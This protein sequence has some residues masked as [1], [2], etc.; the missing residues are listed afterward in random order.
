[1]LKNK[2]LFSLLTLTIFVGINSAQPATDAATKINNILSKM[3]VINTTS[4]AGCYTEISP[5][6]HINTYNAN[7]KLINSTRVSERTKNLLN[8]QNADKS[9]QIEAESSVYG[10]GI[11]LKITQAQDKTSKLITHIRP[12]TGPIIEAKQSGLA[13]VASRISKTFGKVPK[14]KI[15]I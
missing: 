5:D 13:N 2:K 3:G 12:T 15:F 10:L 14:E 4:P 1:M 7:H 11:R 9:E 6:V 8:K